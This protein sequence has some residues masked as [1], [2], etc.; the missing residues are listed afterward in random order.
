[1][2]RYK[3]EDVIYST[4]SCFFFKCFFFLLS[5]RLNQNRFHF[6]NL[7]KWHLIL[8]IRI[9]PLATRLKGGNDRF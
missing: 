4:E 3:K 5:F 8:R 2:C 6:P 9:I 1:M 7:V